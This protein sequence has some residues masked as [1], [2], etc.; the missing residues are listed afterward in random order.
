M[1]EIPQSR[2][3]IKA[4]QSMFQSII[5]HFEYLMVGCF[6]SKLCHQRPQQCVAWK[7]NPNSIA[8]YAMWQWQY[9]NKMCPYG[10]GGGGEGSEKSW[11]LRSPLW[12]TTSL[13]SLIFLFLLVFTE[14]YVFM[15]YYYK[16][17]KHKQVVWLVFQR[18]RGC[19]KEN[20][21]ENLQKM[22]YFWTLA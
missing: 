16:H 11:R 6:V 15:A 14:F 18:I 12:K 22:K 10:G 21:V 8:T 19:W 2:N 3:C 1:P 13:A 20:K 7:S 9:W 17:P 5:K 4:H